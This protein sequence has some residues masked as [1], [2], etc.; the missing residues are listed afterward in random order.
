MNKIRI[1][2]LAVALALPLSGCGY[3]DMTGYGLGFSSKSSDLPLHIAYGSDTTIV[4]SNYTQY[5][6]EVIAH[7]EGA[8]IFQGV[9]DPG[10]SADV[11]Y[12][13]IFISNRQK[14]V[15]IS[16]AAI[17]SG[18]IIGGDNRTFYVSNQYG[19]FQQT[20]EIS[21]LRTLQRLQQ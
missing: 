9:I 13:A 19:S 3:N 6:L 1:L 21:Y 4:V 16:A 11:V 8:R 10:K 17:D 14:Q 2:I 5:S 15:T 12:Q 20:W 18:K 7:A